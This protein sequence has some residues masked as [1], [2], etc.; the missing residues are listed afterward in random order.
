MCS[1]SRVNSLCYDVTHYISTSL[2]K[3]KVSVVIAPC[4]IEEIHFATSSVYTEVMIVVIIASSFC[5]PY[6]LLTVTEGGRTRDH[7][8]LQETTNPGRRL[9]EHKKEGRSPSCRYRDQ[10]GR[11]RERKDTQPTKSPIQ[12]WLAQP[13][14]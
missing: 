2:V 6:H 7:L 9:Q 14:R 11:V 12:H 1:G 3:V 8:P 13:G 4:A 5:Y 10:R